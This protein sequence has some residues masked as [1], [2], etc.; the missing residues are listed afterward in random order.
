MDNI[1]KQLEQMQNIINN[2]NEYGSYSKRYKDVE[3]AYVNKFM[4]EVSDLVNGSR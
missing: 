2:M 1:K 3:I 4:N